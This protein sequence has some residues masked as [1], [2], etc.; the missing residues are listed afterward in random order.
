MKPF[1]IDLTH[2]HEIYYRVRVLLLVSFRQYLP[3]CQGLS[4]EVN[5]GGEPTLLCTTRY[6][7]LCT[8]TGRHPRPTGTASSDAEHIRHVVSSVMRIGITYRTKET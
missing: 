2:L 3:V 6:Y 8:L 5:A 4:P 7:V 1:K